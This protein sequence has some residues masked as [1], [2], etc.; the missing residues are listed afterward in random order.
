MAIKNA[1]SILHLGEIVAPLGSRSQP[2][3]S[4]KWL[5]LSICSGSS[6]EVFPQGPES[7][8]GFGQSF[9]AR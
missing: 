7:L 9:P 1:N 5:S 2:S 4:A 6:R 8:S 3:S